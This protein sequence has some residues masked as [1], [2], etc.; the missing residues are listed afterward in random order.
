MA[1]TKPNI[2][3]ISTDI[4]DLS[5]YLRSIK[6][7]GKSTLFRDVIMEKYG[8]PNYGLLISIG[9]ERGDKLLDNLNRTHV[10][11]Y[12]EFVE[13]KQWL[14]NTKGTEHCIKVVGFDTCDE[15]FP[16]FEAETIRKYN[17]EEKPTKLCTSIKAAYGG[18]NRGVEMTA[19][20]VKNYFADLNDAGFTLWAI[21]HTKYKNI[22]QK[23]DMSDGYMQLSSNLPANYEAVLGDIF[24]VVLTG[25]IDREFDEEEIDIGNGKTQTKRYTTDAVRKLYFRGTNLIDAGGRFAFG[26]VPEYMVF[27]ERNMAKEFIATVEEGM[28]NSR[29][30]NAVPPT[31][32]EVAESLEPSPAVETNVQVDIAALKQSILNRFKGASRDTK[33]AIKNLLLN[34]GHESLAEDVEISV[35]QDID[36]ML[37]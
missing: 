21:A 15:L 5:I 12:K 37:K 16:I 10:S 28:K 25:I 13:L 14:I 32:I 17:V 18:Y 22:K 31:P 34:N 1:F 4:S 11:T 19:D 20:M 27:D 3:K 7:F 26:A 8:D 33:V 6:K 2:N 36:S 9:K 29:S 35:L 30:A 23:G 24:D